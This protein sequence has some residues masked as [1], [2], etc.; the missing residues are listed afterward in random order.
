QNKDRTLE[1]ILYVFQGSFHYYSN[2]M[3]SAGIYFDQ[4]I[5][6]SNELGNDQIYRT[7]K[8]RKIFTDDY[9]KTK[10]Q[11]AKEMEVIYIDSYNKKDTIN[12]LYSLNG[13][14]I[15]YGDM[16]SVSLSLKIF[17]E[18]LRLSDLS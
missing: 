3:D 15:F 6:I 10:Y 14:G 8:I 4:A 7:A 1:A 12:M 5:A 13:L 17:Y 11:M 2:N 9:K 18:A 16:D